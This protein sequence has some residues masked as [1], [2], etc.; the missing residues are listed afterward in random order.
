[1][2]MPG[3]ITRGKVCLPPLAL[4]YKTIAWL[5]STGPRFSQRRAPGLMSMISVLSLMVRRAL[6][7]SRTR[8][9]VPAGPFWTMVVQ[10]PSLPTAMLV[11]VVTL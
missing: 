11:V 8:V 7:P 1:M 6:A 2:A 4:S 10:R 9:A 5:M 3:R